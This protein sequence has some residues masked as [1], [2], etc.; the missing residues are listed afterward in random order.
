MLMLAAACSCS[1]GKE[2]ATVNE[3][4]KMAETVEATVR[5]TAEEQTDTQE[6]IGVNFQEIELEEALKISK[7]KKLRPMLSFKLMMVILLLQ[8][9]NQGK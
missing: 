5:E 2:M 8:C 4:P 1:S 6:S 9:I 7:E 3:K